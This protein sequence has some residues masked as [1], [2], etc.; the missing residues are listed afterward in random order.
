LAYPWSGAYLADGTL[1]LSERDGFVRLMT[2]D[3]RLSPALSGGPAHIDAH[4]Q[5]G[6]LGVALDPAFVSN[7]RVYLAFAE[8]GSGA[9]AG[10]NG[11]AVW[12]GV[13]KADAS[14][15]DQGQVIWRQQPKVDSSGHF[16]GRLVF[17]RLGQLFVTLGERQS[18][19]DDAQNRTN[20]LGK[21]V[22]ITTEGQAAPDNPW[23]SEDGAARDIWSIGHRNVQGAAIHP[24]TGQ[25]WTHEHGPQGGDEINLDLAGHNYGWPVIT[26]GCEYVTCLSI[27]EGNAK[28]GM[29][30]PLTWWPKPSTAPS[31]M[32]FYT[33][34]QFPQWRGNLF[35]G[36]LA[37][38]TLWRLTLKDQE[39]VARESLLPTLGLR[40]RDVIQ[41][42]DGGLV[43]LT[44]SAQGQVLKLEATASVKPDGP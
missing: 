3:G 34:S 29:D 7:R 35:V 5:G 20:H 6:L 4:G 18:R 39:I 17:D 8:N 24:T 30:Q 2:P 14:G 10:L 44:D 1:L 12:R 11:T 26:Y 9:E 28:A 21:V 15:F 25:L 43:L 38:Q 41:S 23:A 37:G 19:R 31:G 13:L 40:I 42:P 32:L 36:A 16:G 27:G 22:R 33:G